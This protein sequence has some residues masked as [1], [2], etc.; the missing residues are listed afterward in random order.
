MSKIGVVVCT[1]AGVDYVDH[2]Y[3]IEV[4]RS[5]VLFGEEEF[6]DYLEITAEEFYKKI[7]SN[8]DVMPKT[9]QPSTGSILEVFKKCREKGYEEILVITIS[10]ALSGIYQGSLIAADMIED[11]K[12]TVYD[13]KTVAY[14][15]AYIAIEASRMISEGKSIDEVIPV[16]D[17]I[18]ENAR[19]VFAVPELKYLVKNGRLSNASGFIGSMMKIKPL[20]E[21]T[22]DGK[23]VSVEKIRT[24]K[25][26]INRVVEKVLEETKGI[27]GE[28]ILIHANNP[29]QCTVI[30]E[31]L[32]EKDI[33]NVFDYP[34]TP[35]VG[36][37]SGPGAICLGFIPKV[38]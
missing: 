6:V 26:A 8:P 9:A 4:I 35:A 15:E 37:H 1:N 27:D 21:L 28:Y 19:L 17:Y 2:P 22:R 38:K 16:L 5:T 36:S 12:V 20:L 32:K 14:L 34:L 13:S 33:H 10:S 30:R 11:L 23:V 18:Q 7:E 3:D 24:L 25:K 29:E 31:L